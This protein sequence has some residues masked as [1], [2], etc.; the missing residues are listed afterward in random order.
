MTG[1]LA[2]AETDIAATPAQVW[3]VLTDPKQL[4]QLW[5]GAEVETDWQVGSPITW[6]GEWEGKPYQDKGEVLEVESGRLLR[7][8]HFSPLT[9]Q[10][11]VPENYHTL[12][13]ELTGDDAT[14]LKLT[15]DNNASE[16]EAE[17]SQ[18]MWEMLVAKVKEAAEGQ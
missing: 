3:E 13:Y 14:H 8:T 16:E 10:P 18:G 11:D 9:G 6:S 12:T 1:Y 15:Q 5:F 4:K 2:T 17:H 7:L